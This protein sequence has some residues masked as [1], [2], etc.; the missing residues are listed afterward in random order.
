MDKYGVKIEAWAPFGE[1]RK[2]MFTNE[3]LVKI[4]EKY[5]KSAAQVILRWLIQRGVIVNCKSTHIERMRENFDVFDFELSDFDMAEIKQLNTNDS[6]F[7]TTK[8]RRWSNG[9][10]T[11]S[12]NAV[13]TTTAARTRKTGR[14]AT[15][16]IHTAPRQPM[17]RNIPRAN[18]LYAK[19][20]Q[21][22]AIS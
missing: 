3:T 20:L 12:K 13:K 2:D 14:L 22:P 7:L 5:N 18:I 17:P 10:T 9:L 11:W 8:I 16:N 4:G 15:P 19:K 1:G 6:L 21:L